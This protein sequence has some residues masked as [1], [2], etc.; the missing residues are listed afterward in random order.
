[1]TRARG[2]LLERMLVEY[3]VH[4]RRTDSSVQA[5]LLDAMKELVGSR[6]ASV[7]VNAGSNRM[8][9]DRDGIRYYPL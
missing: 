3:H 1:M 5:V 9:L 6:T 8:V 7:L 2:K 4:S